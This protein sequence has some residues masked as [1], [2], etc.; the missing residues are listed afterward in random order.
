MHPRLGRRRRPRTCRRLRLGRTRRRDAASRRQLRFSAR[1]LRTKS[2][3][4]PDVVPLH[5]ANA[6]PRPAKHFLRRARIRGLFALPHRKNGSSK[7]LARRAPPPIHVRARKLQS[8]RRDPPHRDRRRAPLSPHHRHRQNLHDSLDHR[9]RHD[10][11]AHLWRRNSLPQRPRLHLSRRRL[12]PLLDF[13]RRPRPRLRASDLQLPRLL[14]RLQSR[15][16]NEKPRA[17]YPARDFSFDFRH[18]RAL[19]RAADVHPRRRSLAGSP[20]IAL[21]RQPCSSNAPSART[22]PLSPPR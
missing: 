5:L 3:R 1:S 12:E 10:R 18:R 7:R 16:R 9:R 22:G 8:P 20:E 4:P 15:R 21:R 13:F 19:L 14:Q 11:L 2:L 17:Q 6:L